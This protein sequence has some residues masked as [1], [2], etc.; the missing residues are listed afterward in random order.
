[1]SLTQTHPLVT[2]D[3]VADGVGDIQSAG[4]TTATAESGSN[5][6]AISGLFNR[7]Y[8][9]QVLYIDD[10]YKEVSKDQCW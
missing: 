8:D 1:M 9:G 6:F 10:L 2:L 7:P 4:F 3:L 5:S